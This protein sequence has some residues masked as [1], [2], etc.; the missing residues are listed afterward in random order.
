MPPIPPNRRPKDRLT[1][2]DFADLG[3][4]WKVGPQVPFMT[5]Y[6]REH[7]AKSSANTGLKVS[8]QESPKFYSWLRMRFG[9]TAGQHGGQMVYLKDPLGPHADVI[10]FIN[11]HI[12]ASEPCVTQYVIL[13]SDAKAGMKTVLFDQYIDP[14]NY[15]GVRHAYDDGTIK[16]LGET[17]IGNTTPG[18]EHINDRVGAVP[19]TVQKFLD[20]PKGEIVWWDSHQIHAGANFEMCQCTWKWHLSFTRSRKDFEKWYNS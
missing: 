15:H 13:D 10:H 12:T 6:E 1:D 4:I 7:D 5:V 11:S 8:G 14:L 18:C 19:L 17:P 2:E 20:T 9:L 16:Y 3:L